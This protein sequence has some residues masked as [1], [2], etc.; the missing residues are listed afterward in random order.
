MTEPKKNIAIVGLGSMG[1]GMARSLLRANHTVAGCD[2]NTVAV[3]SLK[4]DGGL[5]FST[6]ALA[7]ENA[8]IVV[9]V[10]VN[11]AQTELVL[12]GPNGA[13]ETLKSGSVIIS[14]ATMSPTEA[15]KFADRAAEK[16]V[17]YL[18]AP[19][20][21]GSVKADAGKLTVMASGSPDAFAAAKP[22][23]DA[24]A[25]TV[26]ALGDDVGV[27]SSFK[28][29]NQ[30][31]AGVHIAAACEAITFA[32]SLGL[33]ISRVFEVITKSAGNSWMFENRIPHVLDGDYSP[34]SAISIFTK[35]LGIVSDIGRTQ[36]FP[37]P[38]ASAAL[39]L[40]LM[41]EAAGMGRDDDSSVARFLAQITGLNLPGMEV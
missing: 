24:M 39:Q 29:V 11:A 23:L 30:L 20:S 10:V 14:S 13:A 22:A 38:I 27:G 8:D 3:E 15:K 31:L 41:T 35:D 21:G 19:I 40:F 5:G 16:G 32:K 36:K 34:R 7:S 28:I 9:T 2:I 1:L 26:Y 6:P 37:L 18:D 4:S 25:D 33:D 17:L 12:F